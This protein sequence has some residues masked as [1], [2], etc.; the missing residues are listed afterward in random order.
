M[1]QMAA[2]ASSALKNLIA[3]Q[4]ESFTSQGVELSSLSSLQLVLKE[5][6]QAKESMEGF[7]HAYTVVEFQIPSNP[8]QVTL[9]MK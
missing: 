4:V 9:F 5:A 3:S 6:R 1:A 7:L 2:S 8:G